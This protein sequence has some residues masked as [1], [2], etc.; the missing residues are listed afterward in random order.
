MRRHRHGEKMEANPSSF[1]KTGKRRGP[2][3]RRKPEAKSVGGKNKKSEKTR[4]SPRT[5]RILRETMSRKISLGGDSFRKNRFSLSPYNFCVSGCSHGRKIIGFPREKSPF[6][7]FVDFARVAVRMK[8]ISRNY[9]A[10]EVLSRV[11]GK[12]SM[13]LY[14]R[15]MISQSFYE[16][17]IQLYVI[18]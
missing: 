9:D 13:F 17:F 6:F 16:R 4:A 7:R 11:W 1:K 14:V 12:F 3:S 18:I 15:G 2:A 10:D 8:R 5:G